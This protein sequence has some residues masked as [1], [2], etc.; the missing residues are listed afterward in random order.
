MTRREALSVLGNGFGVLGL[1][2]RVA[3]LRPLF[4]LGLAPAGLTGTLASAPATPIE[5][6]T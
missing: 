6:I 3:L 4:V 5:A 1:V 2:R